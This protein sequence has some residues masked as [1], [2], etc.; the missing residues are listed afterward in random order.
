MDLPDPPAGWST[1]NITGFIDNV[2]LNC[3]ATYANFQQEYA[4]LAEIEALFRKLL[5]NLINTRDY[6]AGFFLLRAHSALLAGAH[7]AMA[8]QVA[9]PHA[10]L[11]LCLEN[12]LY[13]L[14]LAQNPDSRE[15]WLR[16]HDSEQAK[17]C[18]RNEFTIRNLFDTLRGL[19]QREAE[20]T[21]K[22]YELCIDC[23]AHPNERALTQSLQV[24][25]GPETVNLRIIYLS[26]DPLIISACIKTA[27]QVG[28]SVLGIFRLV[29]KER[30]DLT[31]LSERLNLARQGLYE[32]A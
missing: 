25:K 30:F 10:L 1:D 24:E 22:L 28:G 4:K 11:R 3:F 14:Y 9:E 6:F 5:E 29:F 18:V 32:N 16:R 17:R 2:R 21:E 13:G 20:V 12:G 8:G 7:L 27:A 23:G 31:G 26:N 15:T 19:N